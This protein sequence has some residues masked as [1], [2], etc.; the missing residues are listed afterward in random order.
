[1]AKAKKSIIDEEYMG[2]AQKEYFKEKL[3]QWKNDIEHGSLKT[4]NYLK[5]ET[6]NTADLNDR[7]TQEEEFSLELRTRD[8]E[9]KLLKK[10]ERALYRISNNEFG[11]CEKCGMEIGFKRLEAR[12]TAELCIDCKEVEERKEKKLYDYESE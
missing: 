10:I 7:A 12:P 4:R 11:Y 6:T 9:R 8:R 3:L 5:D 2:T 1:M